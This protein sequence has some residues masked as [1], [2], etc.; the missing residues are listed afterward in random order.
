MTYQK[1]LNKKMELD[2][3]P[4]RVG[5]IGAGQMGA[6]L[7]SQ[8]EQINGIEISAIADIDINKAKSAFQNAG[9]TE[10]RIISCQEDIDK[11]SDQI[12]KGNRVV[13]KYGQLITEIPNIDVIVEATGVPEV[14]ANI[15]YNALLEGK[16]VVNMNVETDVAIGYFLNKTAKASGLVYTLIA[17]DEP[18]SI[19]E[20]YDFGKLLGFDVVCVGK[21]KNNILDITATPDTVKTMANN[22][23]MNPRMLASF[24]D[25][26]KTMAELT[27]IA[28]GIGYP[29]DIR[30]AHGPELK[31]KDLS[32]VFV[33]KEFGGILTNKYV[34]DYATGSDVAPGVFI[35]VTSTHPVILNDMRYLNAKYGNGDFW[36]IYR[37]YHL[38]NLEAPISIFRAVFDH[39]ET[40]AT[41]DRPVAE[42][43]SIAK[44][45]LNKGEVID[46]IGGYTVYGTVENAEVA[47]K[48][49]YVPL[50][51]IEGAKII[52][53]IPKG[54]P[55]CFSD[56]DINVDQ[57]IF[58]L[59]KLQDRILGYM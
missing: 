20:L 23:G 25:G 24:V 26:T 3:V 6:G 38:C 36:C 19:K 32:K 45:D 40:L 58:H 5:L 50:G 1:R 33:P 47:R 49:N 13:T 22:K 31:V 2:G 11:V 12:N 56:V 34:V 28:N 4:I 10:D 27:S 18:G 29:P 35:I 14:G 57:T 41:N 55:I 48:E 8:I 15:C 9:I 37:P 21:G 30:G 17:G 52:N 59:R 7:V 53:N 16:H 46:Q 44:R 42:L 39:S 51:L 43:I 54:T